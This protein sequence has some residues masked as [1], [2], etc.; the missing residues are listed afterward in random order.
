MIETF[1]N[2]SEDL[3]TYERFLT[4]SEHHEQSHTLAAEYEAARYTTLGQSTDDRSLYALTVGE[5]S[6]TALFLGGTHANEPVGSMTCAALAQ[7]LAR[8]HDL[9]A[10]FD[11]T[12]VFVPV[13]DPDGA[14]LNRGWF[15]GPYTL[16]T[17]VTGGY[18]ADPA[19]DVEWRFP[20][21]YEQLSFEDAP[22]TN[23][24]LADLVRTQEPAVVVSLHNGHLGTCYHC[25]SE[26]F[27]ALYEPLSSIPPEHGISLYHGEPDVSYM[28][29]YAPGIWSVPTTVDQYEYVATET[30]VDPG[31]LDTGGG[32][33]DFARQCR[34]DAVQLFTEVP[35]WN[36]EAATDETF[37]DR[38]RRE[39]IV[40]GLECR[41]DWVG[42]VAREYERIAHL[43][44]DGRLTASV[45]AAS[46]TVGGLADRIE[47][48][49]SDEAY[50]EPATRAQAWSQTVAEPYARLL[51]AGPFLRAIDRAIQSSDKDDTTVLHSARTAVMAEL[52]EQLRRIRKEITPELIPIDD[53]VAVQARSALT[54]LAHLND[55]N[56]F[57]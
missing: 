51:Y 27:P 23:S 24:V 17:Y 35:Y 52:N 16:E 33:L 44:P 25:L 56:H 49:R 43:L 2:L 46:G 19:Q 18:R 34:P 3:P 4:P 50:D 40:E 41:Q 28:E 11:Y 21:E 42:V 37:T 47:R 15:D 12:F 38:T 22:Q 57:G 7:A 45:D 30:D 13:A 39:V 32:S 14:A 9:R 8:N 10:R 20:I 31:S 29:A 55:I 1:P 36:V 6:E 53:L 26:E 5:G 54:G 48:V